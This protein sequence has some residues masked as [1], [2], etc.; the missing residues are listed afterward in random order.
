MESPSTSPLR[1]TRGTP[2]EQ[3]VVAVVVALLA[4]VNRRGRAAAAGADGP[5]PLPAPRWAPR[6]SYR[7]PG[8]WASG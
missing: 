8:S 4:L 6:R 2:T 5:S 1:V 7:A 3:E